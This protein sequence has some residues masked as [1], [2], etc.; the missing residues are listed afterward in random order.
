[1]TAAQQIKSTWRDSHRPAVKPPAPAMTRE[2]MA[3]R[4]LAMQQIAPMLGRKLR[5]AL[6]GCNEACA[7]ASRCHDYDCDGESHFVPRQLGVPA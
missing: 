2:A 6:A 3:A 7:R 4:N 1:M 5:V